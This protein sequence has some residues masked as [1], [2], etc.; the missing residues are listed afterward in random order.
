LKREREIM[1]TMFAKEVA[2]RL[3]N[4]LRAMK[5]KKVSVP[6]G[7]PTK[8]KTKLQEEVTTC[9]IYCYIHKNEFFNH[10]KMIGLT[11]WIIMSTLVFDKKYADT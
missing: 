8:G 6:P 10:E 4:M 7:R 11:I 2:Q 1:Q 3:S 9:N 5:R